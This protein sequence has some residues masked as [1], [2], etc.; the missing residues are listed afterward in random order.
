M[1]YTRETLTAPEA[2]VRLPLV[3]SLVA[4]W[5]SG[6]HAEATPDVFD[7]AIMTVSAI[8]ESLISGRPCV[9]V[10]PPADLSFKASAARNGFPVI[11]LPPPEE[12]CQ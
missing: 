1:N 10:L 11:P 8:E 6:N 7:L 5:T 12:R 9:D 4:A 2:A 3:L